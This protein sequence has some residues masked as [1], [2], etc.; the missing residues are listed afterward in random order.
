MAVQW[1]LHVLCFFFFFL[2]TYSTYLVHYALCPQGGRPR[3]GD[4]RCRAEWSGHVGHIGGRG[5]ENDGLGLGLE[6]GFG[7]VWVE[8]VNT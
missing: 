3:G 8:K 2:R 7:W 4:L 1:P 5:G 6:G